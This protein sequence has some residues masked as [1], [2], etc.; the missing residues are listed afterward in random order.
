M[1]LRAKRTL[2][3]FAGGL[4]A[5]AYLLICGL[6]SIVIPQ[7]FLPSLMVIS[8]PM[9][10]V[11]PIFVIGLTY[12]NSFPGETWSAWRWLDFQNRGF[13]VLLGA[14]AVWICLVAYA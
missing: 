12:T 8:V 1:S 10:L 11:L 4:W 13:L 2:L 7:R 6:A 3:V 5:P 14:I 9:L